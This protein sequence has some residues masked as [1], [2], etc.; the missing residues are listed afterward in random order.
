MMGLPRAPGLFWLG[1][2]A[3]V[4]MLIGAFGPWAKVIGIVNVSVS[5]TDGSNDGWLVVVAALAGIGALA[6][7]T[8]HKGRFWAL[9]TV[10]AGVG[11]TFVTYHDRGN[12]TDVAN[13]ST[14][15][16][17]A[18]Q[19]GWG[20]NLALG[21]SIVFGVV[22]G[23]ALLGNQK[24]PGMRS[25]LA[26]PIPPLTPP[27]VGTSSLSGEIEQLAALHSRGVL[28]DEEYEAAKLR[29]LG[30]SEPEQDTPERS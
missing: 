2:A 10:L 4:A 18:F 22:G 30:L 27:T 29:R 25:E 12:V 17:A 6:L 24:A 7:Y 26:T 8:W 3:A 11:G 28:S 13:D 19:V 20:L 14:S 21:A 23:V 5:G 9:G 16:L 1:L 15:E